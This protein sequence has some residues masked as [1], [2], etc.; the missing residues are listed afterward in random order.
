MCRQPERC[1]DSARFGQEQF[2]SALTGRYYIRHVPITE[3]VYSD[4]R[5]REE[6]SVVAVNLSKRKCHCEIWN[7]VRIQANGSG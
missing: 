6:I 4:Q 3:Y 5:L 2:Y 1:Q 7:G